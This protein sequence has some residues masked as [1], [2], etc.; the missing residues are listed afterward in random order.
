MPIYRVQLFISGTW[1]GYP[2][3]AVEAGSAHAAAE[4]VAG[5][6]LVKR[7]AVADFRASVWE[8]DKPDQRALSFYQAPPS[9]GDP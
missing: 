8:A 4:H 9:A 2:S 5:E 6:P 1:D 3:Q 7:G